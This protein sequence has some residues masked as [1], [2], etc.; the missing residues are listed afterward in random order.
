MEA[1]ASIT[2]FETLNVL[3]E[4]DARKILVLEKLFVLDKKFDF[5]GWQI[6]FDEEAFEVC[7]ENRIDFYSSFRATASDPL[8]SRLSLNLRVQFTDSGKFSAFLDQKS[9]GL[10]GIE[11]LEIDHA[12]RLESDGFAEEAI[13][14]IAFELL[15]SA[16]CQLSTDATHLLHCVRQRSFSEDA[17]T[18]EIDGTTPRFPH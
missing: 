8:S 11:N 4:D 1:V 18:P 7:L 16:W 12:L 9:D 2:E 10:I 13:D 5:V 6:A 14:R 15:M 17:P 3:S